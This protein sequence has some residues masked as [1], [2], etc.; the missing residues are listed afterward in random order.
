MSCSDLLS[1]RLLSAGGKL[2]GTAEKPTGSATT[3]VNTLDPYGHNFVPTFYSVSVAEDKGRDLRS[4]KSVNP[5]AA[6]KAE[7][8]KST[9]V[10]IDKMLSVCAAHLVPPLSPQHK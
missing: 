7:V 4:P 9:Q 10:D 5:G 3:A 8:D 2:A 1:L 6:A